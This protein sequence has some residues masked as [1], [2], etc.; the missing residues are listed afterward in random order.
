[1]NGKSYTTVTRRALEEFQD[2]KSSARH[3][4]TQAA[5]SL[6]L[7]VANISAELYSGAQSVWAFAHLN[8]ATGD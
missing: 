6:K 5:E 7:R 4:K 2:P 3:E 1:M 8:D